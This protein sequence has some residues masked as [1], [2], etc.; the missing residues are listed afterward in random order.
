RGGGGTTGAET[1]RPTSE[2]EGETK[3]QKTRRGRGSVPFT[4]YGAGLD[5]E[6]DPGLRKDLLCPSV[7][8]MYLH[9]IQMQS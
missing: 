4:L 6:L 1:G 2:K 8:R 3:T 7:K 5:K 9:Q